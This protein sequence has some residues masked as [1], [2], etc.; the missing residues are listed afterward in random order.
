MDHKIIVSLTIIDSRLD[1]IIN[2]I[3]SILTQS[4]LPDIIH[5]FYSSE[6]LFYDN[7]ISDDII[8]KL[9]DELENDI[10]T[11]ILFT[12]TENIGSYRKLI[13]ALKIYKNNIIITIDDDILFE[14]DF[15]KKYIEAYHK[16]KCIIY[17]IGKSIDLKNINN[18]NKKKKNIYVKPTFIPLSHII[19]EGYGGILYHTNMFDTHF[20]NLNFKE[21]PELILKNDDVFFR[22]YTFKKNIKVFNIEINNTSLLNFTKHNSLYIN[23]N[24]KLNYINVINE[25]NTFYNEKLSSIISI[26]NSINISNIN[27]H[28]KFVDDNDIIDMMQELINIKDVENIINM[29]I[30]KN[31]I[32][33]G[34]D[35]KQFQYEYFAFS[36]CNNFIN[37]KSILEEKIFKKELK[38]N[39]ILI[40]IEKD[41]MRYVSATNEYKKLTITDFIHLKATYWKEKE[42]MITDLKFILEFMTQFNPLIIKENVNNLI[43][44]EFSELND[45]HILIQDGPLACYCSHVRSMI[46]GYLHFE[47]YTIITEDDILISN[48]ENINKYIQFIPDDWDIIC[49]N[50]IP[51]NIEYNDKYYKFKSTFHSAHFYIIKNRC[52]PFLFSKLYPIYDQVDLLIAKLHNELNIYNITDTVYQKNYSTNTQN[53]LYVILNSPNYKYIRDHLDELHTILNETMNILLPNNTV[54][55]SII[56]SNIIFDVIYNYIINNLNY[57]NI[58]IE[59]VNDTNENSNDSSIDSSINSY[60]YTEFC[61][62]NNNTIL[63]KNKRLYDIIFVITNCCVKGINVTEKT[64]ALMNDINHI[65]S[66]FTLHNTI[67]NNNVLKAYSYGSTSN[68]YLCGNMVIKAYNSILRWTHINHNNIN[69]IFNKELSILN[70]LSGIPNTL[71]I[72]YD[73]DNGNDN[74]ND[75]DNGNRNDNDNGNDNTKLIKLTYMGCSLYNHFILPEDW[76]AQITN[77]FNSLTQNQIYYPEFNLKNIVYLNG[78]LSFI[79]YGLASFFNDINNTSH[80]ID[81]CNIFIELLTLLND[82]F[83]TIDSNDSNDRNDINHTHKKKLLYITF[84]NNIKINNEEKYKKN[85]F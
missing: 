49:L 25:I 24:N 47:D 77:N 36:L 44:N 18:N 72:I 1:L 65:V 71:Q 79:D 17:S 15:I 4:Y 37:L 20:I 19:P 80:N 30:N 76:K 41:V 28:F 69:D 29:N 26:S 38:S 27:N 31:R 84:I 50:A 73:N 81:N 56:T 57:K 32:S 8:N 40:N 48:T 3:K 55:N 5:I 51:I 82:K 11:E 2:V 10:K 43:I 7:G 13:P 75:N 21:F 9:K 83:K 62:S 6:P 53:N 68:T 42:K 58:N 45:T 39:F 35:A 16:Y 52:L 66:K 34:T 85:I 61:S 64:W 59:D 74:G 22:L 33:S 70:K 78:K 67:F 60:S 54:Y 12:N 14:S 23:Y 63:L 46:Y